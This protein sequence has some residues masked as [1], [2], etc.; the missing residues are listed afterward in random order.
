LE[1]AI[2][3]TPG[4]GAGASA[5]AGGQATGGQATGGQATGGQA[6][7]GQATGGQ[8][9]GGQATGGQATGGQ[10]TGGNG[11]CDMGFVDVGYYGCQPVLI[12]L[13]PRFGG[14]YPPVTPLAWDYTVTIPL[15]TEGNFIQPIVAPGVSVLLDGQVLILGDAW[16]PP[17]LMPGEVQFFSF[18]VTATG[19]PST[20]YSLLLER[21]G[22]FDYIKAS[23]T[24]IG[25]QLGY[26]I[27]LSADGRTLAAGARRDASGATGIDGDQNDETAPGAGAVFIYVR[28]GESWSQ[29]AYLK[30]SNTGAVDEFGAALDL[31]ADG[32]VLVVGAP[33]EGSSAQG[34]DGDGANDLAFG[35][36]AA[37]V[38][39]RSG[40][41]WAQE[42]YVKASN[43]EAG[44]SF[45]FVAA[46][47]G[48]AATIAIGA[49]G[50]DGTAA[51]VGG[52]ETQ[53]GALSAGAVYVFSRTSGSFAQ[54][55]YIK[56]S[57]PAA[58]DD[59]GGAVDLSGDGNT[60]VVGAEYED[61]GATGT[62]GDQWNESSSRSGAAYVFERAS[63]TWTQTA[64][65]KA[66]N[67]DADD[68]FGGAVTVSTDGSTIAIGA[69][70]EQ[71][72]S[73]GVGGDP[74]DDSGIR[75]GAVYVLTRANGSW[76]HAA[77]V[78]PSNPAEG[79]FGGA[80]AL[81]ASG[82]VL[83]VGADEDWVYETGIDGKQWESLPSWLAGAVYRFELTTA[84][85]TQSAYIKAPN[86]NAGDLFGH[87]VAVSGDGN[88]IAVGAV[89]ECSSDTGINGNPFDNSAEDSGAVYVYADD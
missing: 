68:Q 53:N 24:K 58:G 27:A 72:L 4:D 28:D 59:F 36:G 20:L 44:D 31:S 25:S 74:D 17:G 87:A 35:A 10:A 50:E 43:A 1:L 67:T 56:A 82:D 62:G 13:V 26:A 75:V 57:N 37:Y 47:S 64:Y 63:S 84:G 76:V 69:D 51:G 71:S 78:K 52:D 45:G 15:W 18:A 11:P 7:G 3:E 80:L 61:S 83:V 30:A 48:D 34:I 79:R 29:Q 38:F 66:I 41:T 8:S 55:A 19:N 65:V 9:T 12:D 23:N 86:T 6:T 32:N 42:H 73:S 2:G 16:S 49:R 39:S 14:T 22:R 33:S 89:L 21:Q 5:G 60:L 46:I 85:W 81:S 70:F 77:Y 88:D 54:T 40:S